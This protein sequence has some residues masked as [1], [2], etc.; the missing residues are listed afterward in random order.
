[1]AL[2]NFSKLSKKLNLNPE[3]NQNFLLVLS[4]LDK[5]D[6]LSISTPC[7]LFDTHVVLSIIL[8]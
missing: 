6:M 1:M 4:K 3:V 7:Q 8:S 2:A 5:L